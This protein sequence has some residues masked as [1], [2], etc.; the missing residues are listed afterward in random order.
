MA[1]RIYN[2]QATAVS[3]AEPP[4]R[5]RVLRTDQLLVEITSLQ[6]RPE[7]T[8]DSDV[9]FTIQCTAV[10]QVESGDGD[11]RSLPAVTR[12]LA[13]FRSLHSSLAE[14]VTA[15][16]EP[17]DDLP[18]FPSS[19]ATRFVI[20]PEEK[21]TGFKAWAVNTFLPKTRQDTALTSDMSRRRLRQRMEAYA[22]ALVGRM[23]SHDTV[24]QFFGVRL[25][26]ESRLVTTRAVETRQGDAASIPAPPI[27]H[28]EKADD[29]MMDQLQEELLEGLPRNLSSHHSRE[30]DWFE[31]RRMFWP[32]ACQEG[33]YSV[34]RTRLGA[35]AFG[36][37]FSA[38]SVDASTRVALK[39]FDAS[40]KDSW[41]RD[42]SVAHPSNRWETEAAPMD[43]LREIRLL[44]ELQHPRI[45]ELQGILKAAPN[46]EG[47]IGGAH[48][49]WVMV[50]GKCA[51]GSVANFIDIQL[52]GRAPSTAVAKQRVSKMI[53]QLCTALA[54]CHGHGIIHRDIKPGNLLLDGD[55]QLRMADFGHSRHMVELHESGEKEEDDL[56]RI[57]AGDS[58]SGGG[59]EASQLKKT[60]TTN[61]VTCYYRPPEL[62]LGAEDYSLSLDVWSVGCVIAELLTGQVL[63][64]PATIDK[65][66]AI[67]GSVSQDSCT[68]NCPQRPRRL[69]EHLASRGADIDRTTQTWMVLDR[70]LQLD[71]MQRIDAQTMAR[72]LPEDS[73]AEDM[74]AA[75]NS[76]R[77]PL[78][79]YHSTHGI[80]EAAA[81]CWASQG[82]AWLPVKTTH[83]SELTLGT[84]RACSLPRIVAVVSVL[85]YGRWCLTQQRG[86][87]ATNSPGQ[88]SL[89]DRAARAQAGHR[90]EQF[91]TVISCFLLAT[92]LTLLSMRRTI[93][94][95]RGRPQ[96]KK[97][98]PCSTLLAMA[99]SARQCGAFGTEVDNIVFGTQRYYD[100]QTRVIESEREI[101]LRV[102]LGRNEHDETLI[103]KALGLRDGAEPV[104]EPVLE[105]EPEPVEA[106]EPETQP[107]PEPVDGSGDAWAANTLAFDV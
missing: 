8:L 67:C 33:E 101:L 100:L 96:K 11:V 24:Q 32:P 18:L 60:L 89:E 10:S 53:A 1:Q 87:G 52:Q 69:F 66:E 6:E 39:V 78:Q 17:T 46:A 65:I 74:R 103:A 42:V 80:R 73:D 27:F 63:V 58:E 16:A 72:L 91:A 19:A 81:A 5:S 35:G 104:S 3:E 97:L 2:M 106:D 71:P 41:R 59:S 37:V 79:R 84:C 14:P 40:F 88:L 20:P 26:D 90:T 76:N 57:S 95:A 29:L 83:L 107:Q 13:E 48:G 64:R 21:Q 30:E 99:E 7:S 28:F 77:S 23:L 93:T 62:L 36:S 12:S 44:S 82:F 15:D 4:S 61:V 70:A 9:L 22:Q 49:S 98:S 43:F 38:T 55:G 54:H 94:D 102:N 56:W 85:Y 31:G 45:V 25:V 50:L 47:G 86:P 105:P 92:R 51:Q 75:G 34:E 68:L